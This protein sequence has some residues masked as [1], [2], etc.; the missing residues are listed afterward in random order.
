MSVVH[1]HSPAMIPFGVVT[2]PLRPIYHMSA[3]LRRRAGVRDPRRRRAGDRHADPHPGTRRRAGEIAGRRAVG[4]MRGHGNVVV[5]GS[6]EEAV[7]RAVYTEVN[8]RLEA[9]AM[10][11]GP[12]TYLSEQEAQLSS[13]ANDGQVHRAWELWKIA[14]SAATGLPSGADA[15]RP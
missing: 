15:P 6:V 4:L 12:V 2:T 14:A 13:K 7:F 5:G 1:T 3:F 10:A 8:A 11:L 9:A